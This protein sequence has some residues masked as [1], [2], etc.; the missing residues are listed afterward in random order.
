MDRIVAD[1]WKWAGNYGGLPSWKALFR[2]DRALKEFRI[3]FSGDEKGAWKLILDGQFIEAWT[4]LKWEGNKEIKIPAGEHE[5]R[6]VYYGNVYP[7]EKKNLPFRL[8]IAFQ[9]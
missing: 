1:A 4:G 2:I 3:A 6:L 5:L 8:K 9:K 7:W